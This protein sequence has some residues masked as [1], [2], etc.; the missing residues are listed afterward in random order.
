MS[1]YRERSRAGGITSTGTAE[2]QNG[3]YQ[4]ASSVRAR[5]S[6][7]GRAGSSS[8]HQL[9]QVKHSATSA[10]WRVARTPDPSRLSARPSRVT[11][12]NWRV[13]APAWGTNAEWNFS[14]PPADWRNWKDIAPFAPWATACID[15]SS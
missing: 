8:A 13:S 1:L 6:E 10:V 12:R 9:G 14:A 11:S 15:P 2:Y 3:S 5:T 7:D 4:R